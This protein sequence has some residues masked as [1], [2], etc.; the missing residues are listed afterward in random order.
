MDRSVHVA[1]RVA[2]V[3]AIGAIWLLLVTAPAFAR[4]Q[5]TGSDPVD[6]ARIT[7]APERLTLTF[8]QAMQAEFSTVTVIGPDGADRRG[9]DLT[10][11]GDS[12]LVPLRSLDRAGAYEVGYRVLSDDGHP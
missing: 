11:E 10:S 3:L 2:V 8:N 12:L 5:L 7:T 4:T 1:G 6:G 9:G